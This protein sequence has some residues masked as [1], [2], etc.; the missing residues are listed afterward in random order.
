MR[1]STSDAATRWLILI[2]AICGFASSFAIRSLDPLIGVIARDLQSD[3]HTI[4]LLATALAIPY[5]SIQPILGAVGDAL[6]KERIMKV[7]LAVLAATLAASALTR[8]SVTLFG[9]RVLSGAAAGGVISMVLATIDDRVEMACRQIAISRFLLAVIAGQLSG[10]TLSG[11]LAESIG[12]RGVFALSS[13]LAVIGFA[14]ALFG[15]Q[16]SAAPTAAFDLSVALATYRTIIAIPRA[17][18]LQFRVHRGRCDFR[19]FSVRCAS[20]G[21]AGRRRPIRSRDHRRRICNG[22][23]TLFRSESPC[24]YGPWG[25]PGCW[26][27]PAR[28]GLSVSRALPSQVTGPWTPWR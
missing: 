19:D 21:G 4:A 26:S 18:A 6:G 10:P 14:A 9:L 15:F 17:R 5:A 1:D 16:R 23:D 22:R 28:S 24:C 25:W 2:P 20:A 3:P 8:D 7:C 11:F 27:P 13:A 12:S